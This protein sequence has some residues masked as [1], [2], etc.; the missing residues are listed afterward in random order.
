MCQAASPA[1]RGDYEAAL[2]FAQEIG[3]RQLKGEV[4][5]DLGALAQVEGDL[6]EAEAYFRQ[7]LERGEPTPARQS[8]IP[9]L[10]YLAE[11]PTLPSIAQISSEVV[12]LG[13][14]SLHKWII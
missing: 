5:H 8:L 11:N 9:V 4:L 14:L 12:V 13:H 10:A 2:E 7:A 1:A 3:Y 6:D